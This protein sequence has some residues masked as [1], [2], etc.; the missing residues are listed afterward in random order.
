MKV[1]QRRAGS[2]VAERSVHIAGRHL[3]ARSLE[4][5]MDS[6][7]FSRPVS[8]Y[9]GLAFRHDIG[10][11]REAFELL[12][13]W[14]SRG[15]GPAYEA[16]IDACRAALACECDDETAR[17]AFVAFARAAGIL[18]PDMPTGNEQQATDE[19]TAA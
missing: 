14:P 2:Q 3:W 12:N 16:A 6:R 11:A 4:I 1:L 15:R 5:I 17:Q 18:A 9:V 19:W 10:S 7:Q 8:I 13:D